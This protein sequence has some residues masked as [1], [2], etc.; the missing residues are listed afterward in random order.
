VMP[1]NPPA[2]ASYSYSGKRGVGL[3]PNEVAVSCSGSAV[4]TDSL[5]YNAAAGP[6]PTP[7]SGPGITCWGI[8]NAPPGSPYTVE[9]DVKASLSSGAAGNYVLTLASSLYANLHQVVGRNFMLGQI[10]TSLRDDIYS[11]TIRTISLGGATTSGVQTDGTGN[12]IPGTGTVTVNVRGVRVTTLPNIN[13][14]TCTGTTA[15]Q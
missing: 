14:A 11:D 1:S 13:S 4:I 6:Q 5:G 12:V 2:V 10:P 3:G 7:A 9:F 15:L 8:S